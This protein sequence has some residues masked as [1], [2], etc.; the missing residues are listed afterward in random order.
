M[1][2]TIVVGTDGS[3]T[4]RQAVVAAVNLAGQNGA[5]LHI[6]SS[7]PVLRH[8]QG[9]YSDP[10]HA[11]APVLDEFSGIARD[12][13]IEPTLHPTSGSPAD[14]LLRVAGEVDADLVVVGNKG[15]KGA[16]RVLG[17]IPNTVAHK[18]PCSVLIFD[19]IGAD[20]P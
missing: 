6:V 15:M 18:A 13:G 16:G 8:P 20:E 4:S 3:A 10:E 1:F 9:G 11:A 7:F 5:A 12:A 14:D 19:S 17:S 2:N